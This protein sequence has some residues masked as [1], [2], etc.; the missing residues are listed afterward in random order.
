[1]LNL[2]YGS[3]GFSENY[4][5]FTLKSIRLYSDE[6]KYNFGKFIAEIF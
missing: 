2:T 3:K 5:I 4:Q 6:I 1:M